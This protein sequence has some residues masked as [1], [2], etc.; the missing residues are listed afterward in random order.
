ML[1]IDD[2]RST[3]SRPMVVRRD[4]L[5]EFGHSLHCPYGKGEKLA[6]AAVD[7]AV[8]YLIEEEG[9]SETSTSGYI[10]QKVV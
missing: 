5:L 10:L 6:R 9:F 4:N 8:R 3:V 1:E 7:C 2:Q